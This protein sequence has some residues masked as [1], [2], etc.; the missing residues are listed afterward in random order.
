[1][2]GTLEML[3]DYS[4]SLEH[5]KACESSSVF[6]LGVARGVHPALLNLELGN[7]LEALRILRVVSKQP[8]PSNS[9]PVDCVDLLV[10]AE[11]GKAE[12]YWDAAARWRRASAS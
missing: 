4:K 6:P 3:G 12:H 8:K 5:F 9:Q 1:M 10:L 7:R 11:Q 2:A